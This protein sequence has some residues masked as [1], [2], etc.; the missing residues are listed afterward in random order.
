[1]K[2]KHS[3][4]MILLAVV[5]FAPTIGLG[6]DNS[7]NLSIQNDPA[8]T[9]EEIG[10]FIANTGNKHAEVYQIELNMSVPSMI[11]NVPFIVTAGNSYRLAIHGNFSTVENWEATLWAICPTYYWIIRIDSLNEAEVTRNEHGLTT[12]IKEGDSSDIGQANSQENGS[13]DQ[14]IEGFSLV[15]LALAFLVSIILRRH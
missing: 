8:S 6:V 4:A 2:M 1:M 7:A 13:D 15:I 14:E 5:Q 3:L 11:E 10:I 9:D 12:Q